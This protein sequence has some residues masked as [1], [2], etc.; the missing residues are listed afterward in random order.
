MADLLVHRAAG[1]SPA[2][3][4][5]KEARM[6]VLARCRWLFSG[7]WPLADADLAVVWGFG[8]GQAL[9]S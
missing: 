5:A 8:S 3:F 2:T 7:W 1:S 4:T 6:V 9:V